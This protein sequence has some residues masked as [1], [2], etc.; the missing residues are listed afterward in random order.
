MADHV[1]TPYLTRILSVGIGAGTLDIRC[2]LL[3][4]NTTADT[5][6]DAQNP[7][8]ITTLDE[9][10]GAGYARQALTGEIVN[11]DL[12]NDRAEFDSNDVAF[13]ALSNSGTGR[14][15]QAYLLIE[16]VDATNANDRNFLFKDFAAPIS[17]GGSSLTLQVNAEGWLQLANA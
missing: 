15:I 1:F 4:T 2:L 11:E 7:A 9:F 17:P 16:N 13:A 3:M 8:D 12:A 6:V 5:D 14:S 10:D